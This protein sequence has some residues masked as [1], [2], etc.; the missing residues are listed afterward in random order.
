M[1]Y[2]PVPGAF[3]FLEFLKEKGHYTAIVTSS[4]R[5]KMES[6]YK[7]HPLLK[8]LVCD[9]FTSDDFTKSKPD[10]ECFLLGMQ[11]CGVSPDESVVFEDSF[12]GLAAAR[13]SGATVVALATT[14]K[15]E[16]LQD[17]ADIIIP[18]FLEIE[19]LW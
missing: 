13:A 2:T 1:R 18:D 16:K 7:V 11:K 8:T 10:P 19:R 17:K 3:E 12:Y 4:N 14:N 5:T 6:A 9:I 15:E